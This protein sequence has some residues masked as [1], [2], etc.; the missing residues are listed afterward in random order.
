[1]VNLFFVWWRR[2]RLRLTKLKYLRYSD[3]LVLMCCKWKVNVFAGGFELFFIF[4]LAFHV[5]A[6]NR[7]FP[8]NP[9]VKTIEPIENANDM[10]P[11]GSGSFSA[12]SASSPDG[13]LTGNSS[14]N[15]GD[16][17][18]TT[19]STPH[20]RKHSSHDRIPSNWLYILLSVVLLGI[21]VATFLIIWFCCI[22]AIWKRN[23]TGSDIEIIPAI[24]INHSIYLYMYNQ[25]INLQ[26][27]STSIDYIIRVHFRCVKIG[28][29]NEYNSRIM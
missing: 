7:N 14:S 15:W 5:G 11:T 23:G 27:R 16:V 13:I 1:M 22:Q 21:V 25:F 17:T 28:V 2:W 8:A 12:T 3:Q 29:P 19:S 9:P 4:V 20:H 26:Y 10:L 6:I 24:G 18:S